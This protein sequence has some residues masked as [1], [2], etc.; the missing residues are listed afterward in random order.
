MF[1]HLVKPAALGCILILL[2]VVLA[3]PSDHYYYTNGLEQTYD[4]AVVTQFWCNSMNYDA[5]RYENEEDDYLESR[6]EEVGLWW[7]FGHGHLDDGNKA[8]LNC[9]GGSL[10][11]WKWVRAVDIEGLDCDDIILVFAAACY[12]LSADDL[13]DAFINEGADAY[14]G[15][16]GLLYESGAYY[17]SSHFAQYCDS[18]MTISVALTNAQDEWNEDPDDGHCTYFSIEGDS[19]TTLV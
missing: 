2:G 13:A 8:R 17:V 7:Y 16:C 6:A 9:N 15:H 3:L 11:Y 4:M 18:G 10:A 19:S 5:E 12:S 14:I 1:V